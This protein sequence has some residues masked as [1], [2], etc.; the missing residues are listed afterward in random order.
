MDGYAAEVERL[1]RRLFGSLRE[2]D[3][4][5]YAAIEVT[6]LGHGG[7]EYIASVLE[8]DPKTIRAG[9]AGCGNCFWSDGGIWED[10]GISR[11]RRCPMIRHT[12][13]V[14]DESEYLA[15]Q[16]AIAMVRELK[17]LANGTPDGKVLAVVER[18]A[19][20]R[21]R[22]FTRDRLQEVLNAQAAGLE[23]KGSADGSA[24]AAAGGATAAGPSVASSPRPAT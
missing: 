19:V 11:A 6:K 20:E 12:I 14:E 4:R 3:R 22:R 10:G 1:M 2:D 7:T 16:Q 21:G 24:P 8:C 18:E 23:K 17:A 5:R 15:A 9:L 13:Q